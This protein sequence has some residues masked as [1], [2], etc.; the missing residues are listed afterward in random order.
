[1]LAGAYTP[2]LAFLGSDGRG[3]G[4]LW[5]FVGNGVPRLATVYILVPCV[6]GL[7]CCWEGPGEDMSG[8]ERGQESVGTTCVT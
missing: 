1:M 3:R 7:G 4:T 6:E 2:Q 8:Y 5:W